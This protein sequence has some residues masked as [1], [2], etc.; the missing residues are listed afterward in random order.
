MPQDIVD[1]LAKAK[2]AM[3]IYKKSIYFHLEG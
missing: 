2:Q 3:L 1:A